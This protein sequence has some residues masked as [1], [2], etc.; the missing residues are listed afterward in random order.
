MSK[1]S[2]DDAPEWA[3]FLAMDDSSEWY[4]FEREPAYCEY[5]NDWNEISV[6]GRVKPATK[7]N[8][9][10]GIETLERRP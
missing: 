7:K 10:D 3:N 2:W 4:W 6:E 5:D 9:D 1:P 8:Q